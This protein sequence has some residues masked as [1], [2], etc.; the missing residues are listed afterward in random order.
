MRIRH[1]MAAIWL[2]NYFF[3]IKFIGLNLASNVISRKK[4]LLVQAVIMPSYFF[5]MSVSFSE[6][7]YPS[8]FH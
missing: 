2:K 4:K 8:V 1:K 7:Y 3:I 5:D 6:V